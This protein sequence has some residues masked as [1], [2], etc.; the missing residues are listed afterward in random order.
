MSIAQL[1]LEPVESS[2]CCIDP[3]LHLRLI[4]QVQP[5]GPAKVFSGSTF[6][7]DI[8]VVPLHLH[9]LP[10]VAF[11]GEPVAHALCLAVVQL[12]SHLASFPC[13]I[14]QHGFQHV[15][16]RCQKIYSVSLSCEIK[17]CD[18]S[19]ESAKREA[20]EGLCRSRSLHPWPCELYLASRQ[21]SPN[22]GNT[23]RKRK[24]NSRSHIQEA[25]AC[26]TADVAHHCQKARKWAGGREKTH[27]T[28]GHTQAM[29]GQPG[30]EQPRPKLA[31]PPRTCGRPS[32]ATG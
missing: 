15:T 17:C 12:Q 27:H 9:G 22:F 25:T 4:V 26:P 31:T 29:N 16:R 23:K 11:P 14:C 7:E 21:C 3:I 10:S 24:G 2:P 32:C 8:D 28:K 13:K 5:Q 1:S 6:L 19:A 30:C 18:I 20:S